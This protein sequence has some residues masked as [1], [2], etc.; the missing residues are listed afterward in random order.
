MLWKNSRDNGI[1]T[2]AAKAATQNKPVRSAEALQHPE[3]IARSTFS[4][5]IRSPAH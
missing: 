2:F 4:Q 3:S 5:P 1:L